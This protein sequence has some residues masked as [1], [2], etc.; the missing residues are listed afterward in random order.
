MDQGIGV[1]AE[2]ASLLLALKTAYS[3]RY[4]IS[5]TPGTER[6]WSADRL[7]QTARRLE[8]STCKEL[9]DYLWRDYNSW[10][11]ETRRM[12]S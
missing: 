4:N 8:A 9:R 11:S 2:D 6:P 5:V 12:K 3:D 1:S 10:Q 7:G